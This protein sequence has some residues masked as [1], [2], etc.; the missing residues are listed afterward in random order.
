ML[1]AGSALYRDPEGLAHAVTDLR[2][3]GRGH[4]P[5]SDTEETTM[6]LL[7]SVKKPL[8]GKSDEVGQGHRQGGGRRR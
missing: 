7:D 8:H 3:A 4:P 6:G 5:L 2:D 1:V